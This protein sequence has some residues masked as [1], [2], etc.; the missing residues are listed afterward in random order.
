MKHLPHATRAWPLI[1]KRALNANRVPRP[2]VVL[3]NLETIA[4]KPRMEDV[5]IVFLGSP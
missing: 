1:T 4:R 2:L 3:V 5:K